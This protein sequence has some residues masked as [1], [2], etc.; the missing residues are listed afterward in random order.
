MSDEAQSADIAS[1]F[2]EKW[3]ALKPTK[4]DYVAVVSEIKAPKLVGEASVFEWWP[5]VI[6]TQIA[7]LKPSMDAFLVELRSK[8]QGLAKKWEYINGAGVWIETVFSSL[9]LC[10]ELQENIEDME[11]RLVFGRTVVPSCCGGALNEGL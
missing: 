1:E 9:A 2:R 10:K 7:Y 11:R 6:I 5:H 4:D 3:A 8:D